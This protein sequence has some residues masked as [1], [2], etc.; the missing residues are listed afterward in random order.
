VHVGLVRLSLV[1][2]R[3]SIRGSIDPVVVADA[4]SGLLKMSAIDSFEMCNAYA[5]IEK[6]MTGRLALGYGQSIKTVREYRPSSQN[7]AQFKFAFQIFLMR[8]LF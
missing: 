8:K 7:M 4:E 6:N 1:S 2:V 5:A 3:P